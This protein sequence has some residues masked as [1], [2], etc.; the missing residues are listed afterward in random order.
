MLGITAITMIIAFA[1]AA[2]RARLIP[3]VYFKS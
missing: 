2:R 1:A 3:I